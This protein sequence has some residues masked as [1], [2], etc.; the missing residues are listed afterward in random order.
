MVAVTGTTQL[1]RQMAMTRNISLLTTMLNQQNQQLATGLKIDGLIGVSSQAQELGQLKSK[2]GTVNN[3]N[4]GVTTAL[5]R[6]ELYALSIEKIIDVATEA[7]SM[8][9]KNRDTA[10]ASTS[11]PAVQA[12]SLLSQIGS[13]LQTRD[14]DRYIFSGTN[15]GAN[16][17]IGN[18]SAIPTTYPAGAV[19]GVTPGYTDPLTV[20][21]DGA[22]V[23]QPPYL[24]TGAGNLQSFYDY[25]NVNLYVDDGEQVSYGVSATESGFQRAIDA[26]VRFRDA[27]ADLGTN[28]ANYQTRVDD[29]LKQLNLAISDLKTT[30]SRNGYKQQQLTEVQERHLRSKDL[31]TIRIGSI[32]DADTAEV[33]TNIANLQTS[34]EA[35][36]LITSKMLSLSL[37]NYLK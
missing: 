5:N 36:Y 21:P 1:A 35:A 6:V 14:G 30:A 37:V 28:D 19:P 24:N 9:I 3:Y 22:T 13:I 18:L 26:I 31:L 12:N 29:A 8:M 23:P 7:Q 16:P 2:L 4:S 15:Y 25:G 20:V 10:F 11:A 17:V 27:T 33:S 32:Q 34:L